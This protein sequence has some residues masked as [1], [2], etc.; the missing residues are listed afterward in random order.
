MHL[1]LEFTSTAF[2]SIW[3]G[4]LFTTLLIKLCKTAPDDRYFSRKIVWSALITFIGWFICYAVFTMIKL[5]IYFDWQLN[6]TLII[7]LSIIFTFM[8][9]TGFTSSYVFAI[10]MLYA[11]FNGSEFAITKFKLYI[12]L[13]LSLILLFLCGFTNY[14]L[15][16]IPN[17]YGPI[18]G[19]ITYIL[20]IL[21]LCKLYYLLNTKLIKMV[22]LAEHRSKI[23][24]F[25]S[26]QSTFMGTVTKLCVL[27]GVFMLSVI[28][29]V[30]MSILHNMIINN[31]ISDIFEWIVYTIT[32]IVGTISIYLTFNM[33]IKEYN[34]F[35]NH[36]NKCCTKLCAHIVRKLYETNMVQTELR[37]VRSRT[38]STPKPTV[39]VTTTSTLKYTHEN[40]NKNNNN[41]IATNKSP[42]N[43]A[44]SPIDEKKNDLDT[45]YNMN[46][47][48]V[49]N[50]DLNDTILTVMNT[51]ITP[52]SSLDDYVTQNELTLQ[53]DGISSVVSNASQVT[54]T[55]S[56][57]V[58]V[59]ID[60]GD[61]NQNE[62]QYN[63]PEI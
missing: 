48:N 15:Y 24:L 17:K 60:L 50:C 4:F 49:D 46:M 13:F 43:A 1:I 58:N 37:L 59:Q 54:V 39:T 36:C 12:H 14:F 21:G 41:N 2:L 53:I 42:Q 32:V 62:M 44:L 57:E 51:K 25:N 30:I 47:I 38:L 18:F 27:Q 56:A 5:D 3:N 19:F 6:S 16:V 26:V 55:P 7:F 29:Y 28:I 34:F 9:P 33:N 22:M 61:L 31:F 8:Y 11:S 40:K 52:A 35:C 45:P 23:S 20:Y 63:D 10:S